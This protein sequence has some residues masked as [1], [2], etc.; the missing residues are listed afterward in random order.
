MERDGAH[1]WYSQRYES[2]G[3][4]ERQIIQQQ[5][6][7]TKLQRAIIRKREYKE[8]AQEAHHIYL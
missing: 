1:R 2:I 3:F 6:A 5:I 8:A 4:Q 7:A